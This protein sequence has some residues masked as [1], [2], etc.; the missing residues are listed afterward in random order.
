MLVSVFQP[1]NIQ[2]FQHLNKYLSV[3]PPLFVS[4]QTALHFSALAI[5]ADTGRERNACRR[6]SGKRGPQV[7]P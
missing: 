5:V 1:S 6:I 7:T 2:T 3:A 4:S